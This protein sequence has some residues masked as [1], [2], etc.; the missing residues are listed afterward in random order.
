MLNNPF[1]NSATKFLA[2]IELADC[3][4][5]CE[6][7][8]KIHPDND[9][10]LEQVQKFELEL[11]RYNIASTDLVGVQIICLGSHE[12]ESLMEQNPEIFENCETQDLV[13]VLNDI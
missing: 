2:E 7:H 12:R 1:A 13:D 5:H 10:S 4:I 9:F 8:C 11:Y 3:I 6:I